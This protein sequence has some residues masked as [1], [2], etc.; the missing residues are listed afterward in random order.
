MR[1]ASGVEAMPTSA[2]AETVTKD[3]PLRGAVESDTKRSQGPRN[4]PTFVGVANT[5]ASRQTHAMQKSSRSVSLHNLD[6]RRVI[7]VP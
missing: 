5:P 2:N 7:F 1:T 6:C 4:H 3:H